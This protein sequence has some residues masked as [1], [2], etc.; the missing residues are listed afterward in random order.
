MELLD[1]EKGMLSPGRLAQFQPTSDDLIAPAIR[2]GPRPPLG[3]IFAGVT[4]D[5]LGEGMRQWNALRSNAFNDP[6][7][8]SEGVPKGLRGAKTHGIDNEK[9]QAPDEPKPQSGDPVID[10]RKLGTGSIKRIPGALPNDNT[11]TDM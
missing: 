10:P 6:V 3:A 5:D 9:I 8:D 4:G 11:P 2:P 7:L 1:P